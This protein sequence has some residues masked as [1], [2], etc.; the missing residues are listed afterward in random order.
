MFIKLNPNYKKKKKKNTIQACLNI[1]LRIELTRPNYSFNRR[2]RI[3]VMF[4]YKKINNSKEK[5][6]FS[7]KNEIKQEK[8]EV[9]MTRK[10]GYECMVQKKR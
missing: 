5:E 7:K 4:K 1:G 10:E 9:W 8:N 3:R 6:G 2:A